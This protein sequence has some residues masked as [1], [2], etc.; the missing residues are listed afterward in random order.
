MCGICCFF[1]NVHLFP[2][3]LQNPRIII[4]SF[5]WG[6]GA[7]SLKMGAFSPFVLTLLCVHDSRCKDVHI[8]V[9]KRCRWF[10]EGYLKC[11]FPLL[12]LKCQNVFPQRE[13]A[14]QLRR[15]PFDSLSILLCVP[16]RVLGMFVFGEEIN[17]SEIFEMFYCVDGWVD[18]WM[19]G[20]WY[21]TP[22]IFLI[23][24]QVNKQH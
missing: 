15:G 11:R 18:G 2:K 23:F 4:F 8:C 16:E 17:V 7:N 21:F 9:T 6:G 1:E 10:Q 22:S 13:S 12:K 3:K 5:N 14:K 24:K 19:G 20:S